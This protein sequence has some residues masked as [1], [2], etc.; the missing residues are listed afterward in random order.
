M[1]KSVIA[2]VVIVAAA[3]GGVYFANHKAEEAI[4]QQISEANTNYSQLAASGE[5]PLISLGYKDVAAN[6]LTSTYSIRGLEVNIDELGTVAT[7]ELITASG[8][9]PKGLADKGS[10]QMVNAKAAPGALQLLP[11]HTSA[12]IQGL[13]L[14]GD[15]D[16]HYASDGTLQFE[17]KTRINDEFSFNYSFSLAQMQQFWQFAKELSAMS[18][19]EQ[20]QLTNSADYAQQML[21]KLST[22]ALKKGELVITN[23]GFIERVIAMMAE[24][25]QSPDLETIRAMALLNISMAEQ[26]PPEIK[27]NLTEFVTT[28]EKLQLTFNF[29]EPLVFADVQNGKLASELS[30][31]EAMMDFANV[32][33]TAN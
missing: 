20:Q 10:M 27:E 5:M 9:E 8:V 17:Q 24:Q 33:L 4:K 29:A 3:S 32:K 11:P 22:G 21:E 14:H 26:L 18:A 28:P 23:N 16:Y 15:Y 31:P 6:V 7:I 1:K 30:S 12:F 2:V 13:A 25:G 19:E